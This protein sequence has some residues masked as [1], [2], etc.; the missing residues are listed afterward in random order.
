MEVQFYVAIGSVITS[1]ILY[2]LLML[3]NL[4]QL[5]KNR[6]LRIKICQQYRKDRAKRYEQK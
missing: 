4:K 1:I 5:R 2:T 3:Y 6:Q